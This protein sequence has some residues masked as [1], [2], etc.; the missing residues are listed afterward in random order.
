M[1]MTHSDIRWG[2]VIQIYSNC[3]C[4][5]ANT[6]TFRTCRII[7]PE[8]KGKKFLTKKFAGFSNMHTFKYAQQMTFKPSL[9]RH[10]LDIFSFARRTTLE[11]LYLKVTTFVDKRFLK[12]L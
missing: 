9:A 3:K 7:R 1:T 12:R 5:K 2:F 11:I 4:D 10:C 8:T 6:A